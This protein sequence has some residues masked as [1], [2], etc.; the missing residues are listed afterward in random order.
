MM[1]QLVN[2]QLSGELLHDEMMARYTSWRVGGPADCLYKPA[3]LNDLVLFMQ[4]L[5]AD[6]PVVWLGLG[7]NI[8]VRDGGIR[9]TVIATQGALVE[10]DVMPNGC[11][12]AEAGVTCAKIARFCSSH[13][14]SDAE[15]L[16]GI[17]GTMGGALA[18]NAGAFGG[19]TWTYVESVETL[20][21]QGRLHIRNADEFEV[22][23]RKAI[24][25]KDEWFVAAHLR[26]NKAKKAEINI[27][28]DIKSLL[29]ERNEKQPIGVASCGSV[30]RNPDNGYAAQ[31][32]EK[33]GLKGLCEGGA[34][35][36]T[37]HA[38]F[39]INTGDATAMDI[40]RLI[41]KVAETVHEKQGVLLE[42]EV[43]IM[44]E[45]TKSGGSE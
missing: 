27:K 19:E 9:G 22:G 10:L 23:Y 43:H 44:G 41:T 39:I 25:R 3:D 30:F 21:R 26:L 11:V 8:L 15:F 36:S 4:G 2:K 1:T 5:P 7:S 34:C 32:I 40:E 12:R 28:K 37:K 38:N 14:L 6:E 13:A 31:L 24:G 35:V 16:A 33:A 20:D 29:A 18:M 45:F 17:P 42:K